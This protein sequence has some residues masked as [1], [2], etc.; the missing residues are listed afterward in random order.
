[1]GHTLFSRLFVSSSFEPWTTAHQ[2]SLSLTVSWS[3]PK[4]VSIVE[5]V[6]PSNHHGTYIVI[7]KQA[8]SPMQKLGQMS[9]YHP[10]LPSQTE[11]SASSLWPLGLLWSGSQEPWQQQQARLQPR[12]VEGS[13]LVMAQKGKSPARMHQALAV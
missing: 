13:G 2:A 3:L 12:V 10:P 6:M 4:F 1:M 8:L 7:Q 11:L 5:L 9:M